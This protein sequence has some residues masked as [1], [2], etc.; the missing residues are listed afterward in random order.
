MSPQQ[1]KHTVS[2]NPSAWALD[3]PK[4]ILRGIYRN[5]LHN[6]PSISEAV[7]TRTNSLLNTDVKSSKLIG[8]SRVVMDESLKRHNIGANVLDKRYNAMS[9][10]RHLVTSILTTKSVRLQTEC[11]ITHMMTRVTPHVVSMDITETI[12]G[13][14][15]EIWNRRGCLT[16]N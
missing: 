15:L 3:R 13:F 4:I 1:P 8:V 9:Q 11:M 14:Y 10:R 6:I 7:V 16:V 12:W 2:T 5:K